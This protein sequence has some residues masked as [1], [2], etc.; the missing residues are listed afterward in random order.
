MKAFLQSEHFWEQGLIR[1]TCV[2][3][4]SDRTAWIWKNVSF[5][6]YK[7]IQFNKILIVMNRDLAQIH[8]FS[9][10]STQTYRPGMHSYWTTHIKKILEF[11]FPLL[12]ENSFMPVIH[13]IFPLDN[14]LTSEWSGNLT[15]QI[16]FRTG[17]CGKF[18]NS[19]HWSLQNLLPWMT[20]DVTYLK[21]EVQ[22]TTADK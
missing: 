5:D 13:K 8:S 7:F 16:Q 2:L 20:S 6:I 21:P 15:D 12:V 4:S 10:S 19:K 3:F 1:P 9:N 17:L 22:P 14:H 18:W 11:N